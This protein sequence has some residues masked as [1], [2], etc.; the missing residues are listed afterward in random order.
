MTKKRSKQVRV[1]PNF[2]NFLENKRQNYQ[3][4]LKIKLSSADAS[5]LLLSEFKN[6]KVRKNKNE[7]FMPI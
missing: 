5:N 4:Q 2:A 1:S 6:K 7:L 3:L